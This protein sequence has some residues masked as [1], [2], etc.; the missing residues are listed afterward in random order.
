[1]LKKFNLSE[2]ESKV[3]ANLVLLGPSKVSTISKESKV[4]QSKIYGVLEKLMEKRLVGDLGVNP[5]EYRAVTPK[6][7]L[8]NLLEDKQNEIDQLKGSIEPLSKL[9]RPRISNSDVLSGI[10]MVKG[11]KWSE[12]INI[13]SEMYDRCEKYAYCVSRDFS[14]SSR[15]ADSVRSCAKRGVEI[16]TIALGEIGES[17]LQRAKWFHD[18]NV[19]IKVFKAKVHP[20]MIVADGKEIL[21]RL[22][23]N[24]T[25][26]DRFSFTSI[27]SED[28]SLVK[29]I[30]TYVKNLWKISK[31]VDF[32]KTPSTGNS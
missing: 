15:L 5:K 8:S 16:R 22:D 20:R 30:D 14:W 12:F 27:L 17:N 25:K 23:Y 29:V 10:W 28:P 3:Y 32:N 18:H 24:P 6:T 9:L 2:Y 19:K 1:M 4:P 26:K 31:P 7:A 11:E 21:L 13:V